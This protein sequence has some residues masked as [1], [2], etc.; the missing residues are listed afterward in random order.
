ML[1]LST[2]GA[3]ITTIV[4]A[5]LASCAGGNPATSGLDTEAAA[6]AT[7]D[8]GQFTGL[9]GIPLDEP[10]DA[11]SVSWLGYVNPQAPLLQH[12]TYNCPI[13]PGGQVFEG[14]H[15]MP[16]TY[17][18]EPPYF[19]YA[20]YQAPL[21]S[22]VD[23]LLTVRFVGDM[24]AAGQSYFIALANY[25]ALAWEF[26]G[27]A[28]GPDYTIDISALGYDYASPADNLY[29]VVLVPQAMLLHLEAIELDFD[30]L[31]PGTGPGVWNVWGR[32]WDDLA[33]G[34]VA[35]G[36]TVTFTNVL[37]TVVYP[38]TTAADGRWGFN[39]PEGTYTFNV[40]NNK[41]FFD[42]TAM[43]IIEDLPVTLELTNTG[44]MV[45]HGTNAA[46]DG[47]VIPYELITLNVF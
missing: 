20:L 22:Y 12:R 17:V 6:Q 11:K 42:P 26:F 46:Y 47:T 38:Q 5:L 44:D 34:T 18:P 23:D 14:L 10:T 8:T 40:T 2:I 45:Y 1:R 41:H 9:P 27:P 43:M 37:T 33:I 35:A 4:L 39:L 25:T 15:G 16:V 21:G 19:A 3:L 32:A 29:F 30:G 28:A 24:E 7:I 36:E 13:H 31:P